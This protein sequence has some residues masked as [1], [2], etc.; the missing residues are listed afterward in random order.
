MTQVL[1][2]L[3]SEEL[4]DSGFVTGG[5]VALYDTPLLGFIYGLIQAWQELFGTCLIAR[6]YHSFKFFDYG[7]HPV[8]AAR[9]KCGL[10]L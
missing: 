9:V 4:A 6:G 2:S 5:L 1:A 8:L 7:L 10:F 3:S